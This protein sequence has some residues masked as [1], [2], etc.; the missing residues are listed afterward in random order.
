MIFYFIYFIS[1]GYKYLTLIKT[2]NALDIYSYNEF[3]L[4]NNYIGLNSKIL[5][6]FLDEHE[7]L[8]WYYEEEF[9]EKACKSYYNLIYNE[10]YIKTIL[11]YI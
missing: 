5:E 2:K 9:N 10:C 4:I 1:I 3:Y 6:E 8:N 7:N 11:Y